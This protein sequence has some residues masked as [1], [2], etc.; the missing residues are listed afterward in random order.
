MLS[1]HRSICH[2]LLLGLLVALVSPTPIR[3]GGNGGHPPGAADKPTPVT[4]LSFPAADSPRV[5]WKDVAGKNA[6]VIVFLSFDCPMSAGYAKPLTDLAGRYA[7]QGVKFVALSATDDGPAR[8]AK[9]AEEYKLGFPIFQDEK[10]RAA[11]ALQATTTPEVFVL[12]EKGEIQYRGLIDDGYERRLVPNRKVSK[13]YLE[14]ALEDVLAGKP[15][16]VAKT[17]P[18][19]CKIARPRKAANVNSGPAYYKDVL[20]I[21]QTHC[22]VCHRPG[23][24]G[25]FALQTYKQA[26]AWADDIKQYTHNR[27]M[28]PWKPRDGKEFIGDRRMSTK[29]IDTLA[30]W[31]NAGCPEGDPK[32]APPTPKFPDGW[33][34]GKPDLVLEMPDDFVLGPTGTDIYRVFVFPTG[35]TEDKYVT[36][37]Q[38]LP[39]NPRVVHHAVTLFD[40]TGTVMKTQTLNQAAELKKRKPGDVDVGPGFTSGMLPGV[41]INATDLF[42][43]RPPFGPLGG[44]APGVVPRELTPGTGYLLPKGSDFALQ[45]HYHRNGRLEKDRTRVGLYFAKK[46]VERH[47]LG[48]VIPGKFKIDKTTRDGLGYIPA[49]ERN[50]V[51]RGTW[52]ALEDCTIHA[53]MPH[54]HLIGKSVKITLTPPRRGDAPHNPPRGKTETLIDIPDW[55]YNWQEIYYLKTP[56]KVSAGTQFDIEA[57]FD[58]SADNPKNPNDPPRDVHF[59][60]QTTDEMLFG[61]LGA[62][63]D[64]PKK[65]VPFAITQGP[66]R[67]GR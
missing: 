16:L 58:N 64:D 28:P 63:K 46:P 36:A 56:L 60:E 17:E 7:K 15:I 4:E 6:T 57:V 9:L 35:L 1:Q 66:F 14:D 8:V 59:A 24:V 62:T 61:L 44:W 49:G 32:D 26:V 53:V 65:G 50:F 13:H 39:G 37:M 47:V 55:D 45:L 51:A 31:V 41:R 23:E 34:L 48:L 11:D 12:N 42:A 27:S 2:W 18:I 20:P 25:P 22:Q 21:L 40:T 54:M 67:L 33:V 5:P 29:E 43:R 10:L 52:Y 19:G 30:K 3:A 38:V